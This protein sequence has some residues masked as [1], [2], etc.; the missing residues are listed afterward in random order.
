M[1]QNIPNRTTK[2]PNFGFDFPQIP[3]NFSDVFR[4]TQPFVMKVDVSDINLSDDQFAQI[5]QA[6]PEWKIELSGKGELIFMPSTGFIPGVRNTV[7]TARIFN[8]AEQDGTG[9]VG[10]S[11]TMFVLPN[12]ARRSP[13]VS[14]VLRARLK[15]LTKKQIQGYAPLAPDFVIELRSPS[16]SLKELREKMTEYSEN[17]VRLGWLI[18]PSKKQVYLYHQN[19][20]VKVL[21][22]PQT[23]SGENVL[24]GLTLNLAEIWETKIA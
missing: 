21:E 11:S 9:E 23:L 19:Q 6:N 4:K 8:W 7:L 15:K 1:S 10:D 24:N 2:S 17:G 16:D 14:W 18:D 13:D 12:G 22:N 3:P 5:E 20:E